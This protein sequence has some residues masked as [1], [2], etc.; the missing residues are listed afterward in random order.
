V[1]EQNPSLS[2]LQSEVTGIL[3]KSVKSNRD[4]A[5]GIT[6]IENNPGIRLSIEGSLPVL[7]EPNCCRIGITGSPGVGKSSLV[8]SLLNFIDLEKA[9]VAVIA[10]DPSSRKTNGALL[11]D[12][13]RVSD[14]SIFEKIY[15][16]SLASRGSYGGLVQN[17]DLIIEFLG[18]CGFDLVLVETVGVGQN[19]VDIE[20]IVD[21]L[22][23]VVDSK[24]GDYMQIAKAGVMEIGDIFFVN[25]NDMGTN[26]RYIEELA[27][28]THLQKKYS[29]PFEAIISGSTITNEGVSQIIDLISRSMSH[30][31]FLRGRVDYE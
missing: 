12:R 2:V 13:I 17:I 27:T 6:I 29:N 24:V 23:H 10:I 28:L 31:V 30:D 22:I 18:C 4:I 21:I 9:K 15:F 7:N 3:A 26:S 5:R 11:A 1:S 8:N 19:E 25:K 20:N 14:N 16:R